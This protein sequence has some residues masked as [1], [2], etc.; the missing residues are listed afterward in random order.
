VT[1]GGLTIA[2]LAVIGV[3]A[4]YLQ[5]AA[6]S[7]RAR[8]YLVVE[9]EQR[10]G[11]K[12]TLKNFNWSFWQQHIHL[13]DLTLHGLEPAGHGALAH[14]AHIDIGLNFRTLIEHRIDLFELTFTQPVSSPTTPDGRQIL[15]QRK[16]DL[17]INLLTFMSRSRT[18]M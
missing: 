10:T 2:T 15:Q 18:S 11:A 3:I 1:F 7:Q 5:S 6:F 13:D 12:V 14:F 17:R 9:I 8:D 4:A 16:Q